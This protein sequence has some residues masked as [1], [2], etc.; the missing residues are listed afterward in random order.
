MF[1]RFAVFGKLG[2]GAFGSFCA[3]ASFGKSFAVC[4]GKIG[5]LYFER[6]LFG[7]FGEFGGG[8]GYVKATVAQF[9]VAFNFGFV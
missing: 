6:Q 3:V 8:V 1:V 2:S 4:G 7:G 5:E 9:V